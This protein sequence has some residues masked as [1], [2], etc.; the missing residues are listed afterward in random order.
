MEKL[1][2]AKSIIFIYQVPYRTWDRRL[3]NQYS[4]SLCLDWQGWGHAPN[5]HAGENW[6]FGDEEEEEEE[7]GHPS[8]LSLSPAWIRWSGEE[9][10][11]RHFLTLFVA[12]RGHSCPQGG[13]RC[14]KIFGKLWSCWFHWQHWTKWR[15]NQPLPRTVCTL[16]SLLLLLLL[17]LAFLVSQPTRLGSIGSSPP[18]LHLSLFFPATHRGKKKKTLCER[19]MDA[20]FVEVGG[21]SFFCA[22]ARMF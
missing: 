22:H 18:L 7:E 2:I 14:N 8:F 9:E 5:Y 10:E 20:D 11:A 3:V 16:S 19:Q 6:V 17:C 4:C 12:V 21:S 1:R 13:W 15:T